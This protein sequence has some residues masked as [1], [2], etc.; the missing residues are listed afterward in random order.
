MNFAGIEERLGYSF[1]DKSFLERALTLSSADN[2][3]N[4]ETLEFFGDAILEFLV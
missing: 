3:N 1:A 4:N 2:D